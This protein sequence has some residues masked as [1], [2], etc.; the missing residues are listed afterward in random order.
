MIN[1]VF[2]RSARY[3]GSP[4]KW[5]IIQDIIRT[6]EKF[7]T[8]GS[9]VIETVSQMNVLLQ[10]IYVTHKENKQEMT[11]YKRILNG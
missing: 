11:V 2:E 3:Y 6:F 10:F 8:Y 4:T 1:S 9:M 5:N 7:L